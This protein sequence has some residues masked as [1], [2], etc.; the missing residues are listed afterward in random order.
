MGG[1]QASLQVVLL[2]RTADDRVEITETVPVTCTITDDVEPYPSDNPN[3]R[4]NLCTK[5]GF[6]QIVIWSNVTKPHLVLDSVYVPSTNAQEC[7]PAQMTAAY[8]KFRFPLNSC[9][10]QRT[11]SDGKVTY[12]VDIL[13]EKGRRT[14]GRA[15]ISRD[16]VFRLTAR[17]HFNQEAEAHVAAAVFT[18]P[19]PFPAKSDGELLLELRIAKDVSYTD[20]YTN[21]EYPV[22][23]LLRK[24]VYIEV[25]ILNSVDPKLVLLLDDCW[26]TPDKDP[27]MSHRW[28]L[29]EKGC[30]FAGDNYVTEIQPVSSTPDVRFP[31]HYKRF[32]M[33]MFAFLDRQTLQPLNG[34][35]GYLK[36]F[37]F[38]RPDLAWCFF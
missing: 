9:G 14:A 27:D 33:K 36:C 25:R 32:Q 1:N 34:S 29:L 38:G 20:Y 10:A 13:A 26:A 21:T 17:C 31:T 2:A 37:T 7:K 24:V 35:V 30:P 18:I 6:F 11:V 19:P 23:R 4:S 28:K 15:I 22:I 12:S 8:V 3:N 16:S 5:D